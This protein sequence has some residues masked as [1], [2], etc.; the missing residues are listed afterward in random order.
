MLVINKLSVLQFTITN[1]AL[2]V[3]NPLDK[4]NKW[5]NIKI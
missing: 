5:L 1:G 3:N 2:I 4:Y